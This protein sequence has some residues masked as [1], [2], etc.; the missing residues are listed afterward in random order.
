MTDDESFDASFLHQSRDSEF[1]TPSNEH[2]LFDVRNS[3]EK[4]LDASCSD[5][6]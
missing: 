6:I 2:I 3:C 1:L 5:L 4:D